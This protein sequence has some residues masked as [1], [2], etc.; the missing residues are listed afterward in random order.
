MDSVAFSMD[1]APRGQGRPRATARNGFAT[2]YKDGKSRKYE[3]EVR[4]LARLAMGSK[5][6][7]EGPLSVSL[8]FRLPIPKSASK[9]TRDA[10]AA[11]EIA[12][13]T[14][15]DLSNMV[16][17][18]EDGMNKVVYV[19]DAQIVRNF[20]TKVYATTPGVDVRVQELG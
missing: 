17:S 9:R 14:K 6:P 19:D 11:G 8:R 7:F 4:V 3:D 12:P 10:M 16:K 20:N 18:I 1:G 13:T 2:V 5:A 15:P